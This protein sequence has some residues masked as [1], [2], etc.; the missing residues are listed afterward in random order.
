[1]DHRLLHLYDISWYASRFS[2]SPHNA[3]SICL[4]S[5]GMALSAGDNI[6]GLNHILQELIT[7][8][9]LYKLANPRESTQNTELLILITGTEQPENTA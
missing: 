9:A 6:T 1:M 7:Q 2:G 8:L 4:K 5:Q 3:V